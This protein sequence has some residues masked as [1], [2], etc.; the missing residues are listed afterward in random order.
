MVRASAPVYLILVARIGDARG[1]PVCG[2]LFTLRPY[3]DGVAGNRMQ[4]ATGIAISK[5][6]S[7]S[8]KYF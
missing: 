5:E 4:R 2:V 7:A 8:E 1:N 6:N 3:V